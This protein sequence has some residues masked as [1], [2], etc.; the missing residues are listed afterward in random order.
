M[1]PI[2]QSA[3][4]GYLI[5]VWSDA[6]GFTASWADA[7]G[8][9]AALAALYRFPTKHGACL[10]ACGYIDRVCHTEAVMV[11]AGLIDGCFI[12]REMKV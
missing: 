9:H 6:A 2:A 12:E 8:S 11:I 1:I 4:R 10:A 5:T 3:Y 7:W